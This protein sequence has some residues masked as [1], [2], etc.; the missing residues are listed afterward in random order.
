M[1]RDIVYPV[2]RVLHGGRAMHDQTVTMPTVGEI[3][4]RV[5][6]PVHRVEYIIRARKIEPSGRAGNARVFTDA[7]VERI[8][9]ELRRIDDGKGGE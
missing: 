1:V 7:D 8:A 4:R 2:E 3:S 5:G 9:R 6:E